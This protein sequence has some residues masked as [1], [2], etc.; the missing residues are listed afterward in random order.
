MEKWSTLH[1]GIDPIENEAVVAELLRNCPWME[2]V[3][4]NEQIL[5]GLIMHDGLSVGN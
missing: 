1:V 4:I 5:P 3:E 2:L